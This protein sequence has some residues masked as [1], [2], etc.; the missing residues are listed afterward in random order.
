MAEDV[1][2]PFTVLLAHPGR[3]S[4]PRGGVPT[5]V[6]IHC[7]GTGFPALNTANFFHS[8]PT[9]D[10]VGS[11]QA[12]ADDIHGYTCVPDDAIANG[13]PPLN[14]EGLHIE[15]PG[16]L[17]WSRTT[18]L[19]HDRQLR[20]VA[21]HVAQWCR[22][23]DIPVVWLTVQDLKTKGEKA[24]GITSHNNVSLAFGQS[25]HGD[26]G[27][28][29][30][31]DVFMAYVEMYYDG[32]DD[33][34]FTQEQEDYLKGMMRFNRAD[35]DPAADAPAAL[36]KGFADAKARWQQGQENPKGTSGKHHHPLPGF[37]SGTGP[38]VPD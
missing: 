1:S 27:Q 32:G 5:S 8:P 37:P 9:P 38:A 13:A 15:Q 33:M 29:F 28:S 25:N 3:W 18:W 22:K 19:S 20:R 30:P 24:K 2:A 12:V 10:S 21:Y 6:V 36:K 16:R 23:Y 26:P 4:Q 17:D 34:A 11:A 14:Q 35:G 31:L 7:N